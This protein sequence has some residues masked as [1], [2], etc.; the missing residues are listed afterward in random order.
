MNY[1]GCI[2]GMTEDDVKV[3]VEDETKE[4]SDDSLI[5]ENI[6]AQSAK[7]TRKKK[8]KHNGQVKYAEKKGNKVICGLCYERKH[9]HDADDRLCRDPDERLRNPVA[10][11]EV[12]FNAIARENDGIQLEIYGL[13]D[14]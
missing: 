8:E 6:Y 14:T 10:N 12:C 2:Y 5:Y 1:K 3:I 11:Q 7:A 9:W 13:Q 4:P